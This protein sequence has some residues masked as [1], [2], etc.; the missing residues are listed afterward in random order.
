MESNKLT[1][2]YHEISVDVLNAMKK[3][4][5]ST[6][7]VM[8]NQ[9]VGNLKTEDPVYIWKRDNQNWCGQYRAPGTFYLFTFNCPFDLIMYPEFQ[10]FV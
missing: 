8:I 1:V 2:R 6:K 10:L 5:Y 9:K 4:L 7:K 3:Q